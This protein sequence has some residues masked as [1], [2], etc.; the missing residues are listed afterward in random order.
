MVSMNY[1]ITAA[2]RSVKGEKVRVEGKLPAVVY[3]AGT[4]AQSLS[5]SPSDFLKLYKKAG[6][7]SLIDLLLDGKDS[8]KV[9]VQDVQF[10]AV[11]DQIIHVDFRRIDMSKEMTAPVT[12]RFTGEAPIV[13]SSGGTL[14]TT[15]STVTVKCLPKDLVSQIEVDLSGL[16]SYDVTI[17]VKDI[18]VPTGITI[19]NPQSEDLVAKATPALTE[20]QIKAME[21]ASAAADVTKIVSVA[22]EKKAEKAAADAADGAAPAAEAKEAKKEEKK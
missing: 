22:D 12:L 21:D 14:V 16:V 3:G 10:D 7:S 17:K 20:E 15:V 13:K 1:Q 5:L 4:E 2:Q 8:G 11:S 18:K 9:L 6:D 19:T